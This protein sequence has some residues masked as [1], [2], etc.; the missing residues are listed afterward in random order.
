MLSPARTPEV[1]EA[2]PTLEVSKDAIIGGS[3]A[4]SSGFDNGLYYFLDEFQ[5]VNDM[6]VECQ[7]VEVNVEHVDVAIQSPSSLQC[8]KIG[9]MSNRPDIASRP[10]RS[11]FP[12]SP[13]TPTMLPCQ[14]S[15]Q[16][17][18]G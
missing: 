7:K 3:V 16:T 2:E 10:S 17:I 9:R 15:Y 1:V 18:H 11:P 4:P 13:P 5:N 6:E 12:A 14:G 8:S